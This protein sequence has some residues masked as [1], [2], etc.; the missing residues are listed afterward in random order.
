MAAI[1]AIVLLFLG[2]RARSQS[3]C[4][5]CAKDHDDSRSAEADADPAPVCP[6]F[7]TVTGR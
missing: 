4:D 6:A 5:G 7:A 2:W 3:Q 1:V